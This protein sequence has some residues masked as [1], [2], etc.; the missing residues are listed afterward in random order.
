MPADTP[1]FLT[2]AGAWATIATGVWYLFDRAEATAS[3][4]GRATVTKWLKGLRPGQLLIAWPDSFIQAFD[5]L[6][7]AKHV[8]WRCFAVSSVASL[9]AVLASVLMWAALRPDE[10]FAFTRKLDSAT[11]QVFL[12]IVIA[13]NLIPDYISLLETR[14]VI[15]WMSRRPT[16]TVIAS[17]LVVDVM[18]TALIALAALVAFYWVYEGTIVGALSIVPVFVLRLR[19]LDPGDGTP[20]IFFYAAFFTSV[21]VWL[22]ALAACGAAVGHHALKGTRA[23]ARFFDIEKQP[24]RSMGYVA[25]LLV[26]LSFLVGWFF[27]R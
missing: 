22:Y 8:S 4:A 18:A 12:L 11:I 25:V 17:L 27:V 6:F 2:Y 16:W 13:V 23:F 1:S 21:W 24:L 10:F 9:F 14:Y 7:G 3:R 20:G 26:T 19:A 15:L 5:R